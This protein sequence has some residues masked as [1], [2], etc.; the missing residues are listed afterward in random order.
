MPPES[1]NSMTC[2]STEG[3]A[4]VPATSTDPLARLLEGIPVTE[5]RLGVGGVSTSALEGGAGPPIVLLHGQGGF[6]AHWVRVIPRLVET[7]RV[8]APD[9]PGLGRS[10]VRS[11]RLDGPR[12]VGWLGDL[13]AQT[14]AE[15]PTVVG[16]SLGGA[17]AA[18]FAVQHEDRVRQVVLANSGGLGRALPAPG[19]LAALARY[20]FRHTP[21][22]FDRVFRYVVVDPKAV[23][24]DWGDRWAAFEA[25]DMERTAQ[26]SVRAA[27]GQLLRRINMPR[28][29]PD[30]LRM[31]SVPVSLIWSRNDRIT[32]FRIA[33]EAS[34][35]YGWPLQAIDNC[36]HFAIG[37]RPGAFLEALRAAMGEPP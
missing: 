4:D 16:I 19:A 34:T 32:R 33:Q 21:G 27:D 6:A 36:G 15:P 23:R 3:G 29:P 26:R 12:L 31:I 24:A 8:V 20:N 17:L 35:R 9:L 5:R 22:N 1:R 10:E 25:Y 11:G 28:I 7:H 18:R 13:I 37:E 2:M 30:Q 14:C